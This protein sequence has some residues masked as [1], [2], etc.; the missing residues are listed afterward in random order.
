MAI[1]IYYKFLSILISDCRIGLNRYLTYS[2]KNK[3]HQKGV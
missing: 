2:W 3:N 1:A